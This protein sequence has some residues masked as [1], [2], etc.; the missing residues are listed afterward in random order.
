MLKKL[1]WQKLM[2]TG[3][4]WLEIHLQNPCGPMVNLK[5]PAA[6]GNMFP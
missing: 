6:L 3:L 1:R 4:N 5:D 2:L